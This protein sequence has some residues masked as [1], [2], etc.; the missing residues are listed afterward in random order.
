MAEIALLQITQLTKKFTMFYG[1][2][3]FKPNYI[4]TEC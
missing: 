4:F 3:L 1:E 2:E